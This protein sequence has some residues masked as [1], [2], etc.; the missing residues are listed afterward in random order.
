MTKIYSNPRTSA[1]IENWPSGSK[2]VTA[3]FWIEKGERHSKFTGCE[4]AVRMTTGAEKKLT[5]ARKMRIVDCDDGR[6]YIAALTSY[7]HITIHRGD[8]KYSEES[9][10]ETD[11]RYPELLALFEP[12]LI[13]ALQRSSPALWREIPARYFVSEYTDGPATRWNVIDRQTQEWVRRFASETE[14]KEYA[15]Q[16]IQS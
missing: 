8:M 11:P 13:D 1:V 14:A 9:V 7:G 2:R 16:L 12:S 3:R 15:N 5:F 6:T 4:R 10:F